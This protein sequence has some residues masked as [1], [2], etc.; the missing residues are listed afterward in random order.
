[1]IGMYAIIAAGLVAAGMAA[2]IVVIVS[3]GVHREKKAG[4]RLMVSSPGPLATGARAV[5]SL[6]VYR[7]NTTWK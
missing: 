7:A 4:R 5:T 6:G 3:V 2:G 1:M